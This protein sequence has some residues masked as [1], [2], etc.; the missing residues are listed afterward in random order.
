M[1]FCANSNINWTKNI[2]AIAIPKGKTNLSHYNY[3]KFSLEPVFVEVHGSNFIFSPQESTYKTITT[4]KLIRAEVLIL[5]FLKNK[6]ALV[7]VQFF[8]GLAQSSR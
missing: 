1:E 6:T 4:Q 8:L 7:V 2:F 3:L 5:L